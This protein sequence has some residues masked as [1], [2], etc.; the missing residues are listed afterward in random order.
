MSDPITIVGAGLS[1]LIA[2]NLIPNSIVVE[3]QST[4][5]QH[6]A[7]LRFRSPAVGDALGIPFR[8]VMVRKAIWHDGDFQSPSIQLSNLYSQKVAGKILDRSIWNLEAEERWIAPLAF[9]QILCERLDDT[10]RVSFDTRFEFRSSCISTAPMPVLA[11]IKKIAHSQDFTSFKVGVRRWKIPDCD[12]FQTIYFPGNESVYRAS[13]TGDELIA[14]YIGAPVDDDDEILET[15]F[16]I[17]DD[18]EHLDD[19]VTAL[20]KI[21]PIDERWRRN[22]IVQMT[23]IHQIY[24]L[25]RFAT[26]RPGLLQDDVLKDIAVIKKMMSGDAYTQNLE[27]A[28]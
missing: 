7:V 25:G 10:T 16:G 6:K 2:A 17:L 8:K 5:P 24:S 12:V 20:G 22:F 13:I 18:M 27:A 4:F 28:R 26:W 9:Q 3:A 19:S 14:E 21:T 1:G 23:R 15:V 11:K